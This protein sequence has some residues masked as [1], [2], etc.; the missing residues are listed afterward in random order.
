MRLDPNLSEIYRQRVD[1]IAA[2]LA[3]PQIRSAALEIVRGL[4][5]RVTVR[6]D[7]E[8]PTLDLE[9]ALTAMI[10]LA[11][12]N[13]SPLGS[14][15]E[16][17]SIERPLKVV[18]GAGFGLCRTINKLPLPDVASTFGDGLTTFRL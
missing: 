18:A 10:G 9:G 7:F 3:D 2:A 17:L 14:G 11:Q 16:G 1:E 6:D 15:L 5:T 12:N 8:G 13:K 4:I